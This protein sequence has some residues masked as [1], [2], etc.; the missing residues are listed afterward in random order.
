LDF[1]AW[2]LILIP[3]LFG[4]GWIAA[5]VDVR[6]IV[7]ESRNLP[8]SYF[9]GLNFLLNE[10]HDKAIDAFVEVAKLDSETT[11]LHFA[12]GNLFRRRGEIERA[13]RVHQSLLSR[14]D[15]PR[16]DREHALHE[17]AQD[18]FKAGMFDR[19]ENAFK[20]VQNTSYGISATR[21][22]IRIYEAEHDWEK[23]IA[24]AARLRELTDEPLPQRVH[25]H[26]ERA[27]AALSAK[28]PDFN[29]VA[30][31]LDAA[32][33]EAR[34]NME[35]GGSQASYARIAILRAYLARRLGEG[36]TERQWLL[37]ALERSPEFAGL[38]A[39]QIMDNFAASG[40]DEEAISLLRDHYF[41]H[42]S[43]DVFEVVFS[44]LRKKGFAP[45]W[46]FAQDSLRQHPSLLGF[47]KVLQS[48]LT[49]EQ[50]ADGQ[51]QLQQHMPDFDLSLLRTMIDKHTRRMDKYACR[52]CGFQAQ[53]YYWQCPGCNSWETYSPRRPEE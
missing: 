50:N 26:C 34:H 10:D 27:Q 32:E 45:A 47:D 14:S 17:I 19:A 8:D 7:S 52:V 28:E 11:E 29:R 40:Q 23:A 46:Q 15:L 38:V 2:W 24:A 3:I 21:A 31:E 36:S 37:S 5:K 9:R 41:A 25:Y 48:E 39:K 12:L 43:L 35:Q 13:I 53:T 20:E 22:L 49:Q 33:R 1:E 51:G 30:A 44:A 18:Y 4:L 42:P 16:P 6:Q